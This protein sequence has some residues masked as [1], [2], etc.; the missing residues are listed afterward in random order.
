MPTWYNSISQKEI[1]NNDAKRDP[2]Q[3][4]FSQN[5]FLKGITAI[6]IKG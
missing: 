6:D 5:A 4:N 1:S 2:V 3:T